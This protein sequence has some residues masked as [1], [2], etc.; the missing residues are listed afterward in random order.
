MART[1]SSFALSLVFALLAALSLPRAARAACEECPFPFAHVTGEWLSADGDYTLVI[2]EMTRD[3]FRW[4]AAVWLLSD[5]GETLATGIAITPHTSARIDVRIVTK[6]GHGKRL[7]LLA[8]L[9][10]RDHLTMRTIIDERLQPC[11]SAGSCERF[12]KISRPAPAR[13]SGDT[14]PR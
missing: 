4:G 13:K 6:D 14:R 5:K 8:D 11:S 2:R 10:D 1:A 7:V 3:T 9:R 12:T